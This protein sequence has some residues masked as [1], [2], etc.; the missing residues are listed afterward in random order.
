MPPVDRSLVLSAL[1]SL[2]LGGILTTG[3]IAIARSDAPAEQ[4]AASATA[5]QARP[6]ATEQSK[7]AAPKDS[8]MTCTG[9]K[10]CT[11]YFAPKSADT[12][13][14]FGLSVKLVGSKPNEAN[15]SVDGRKHTAKKGK[16][17]A[18]E[19]AK[20]RFVDVTKGEVALEFTKA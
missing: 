2:V 7:P 9:E 4:V 8:G 19:G 3:G 13:A 10:T 11:L 1:G 16:A 14:P 18:V 6:A 17:V 20:V 5:E 15:F 12:L